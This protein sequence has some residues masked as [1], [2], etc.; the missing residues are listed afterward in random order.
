MHITRWKTAILALVCFAGL[1]AASDVQSQEPSTR[2]EALAEVISYGEMR[3]LIDQAEP[4]FH[5][6]NID[7]AKQII[8]RLASQEGEASVLYALKRLRYIDR[9]LA[10][11]ER[12]PRQRAFALFLFETLKNHPVGK[13]PPFVIITNAASRA[14][15]KPLDKDCLRETSLA[16]VNAAGGIPDAP[17]GREFQRALAWLARSLLFDEKF[18]EVARLTPLIEQSAIERQWYRNTLNDRMEPAFHAGDKETAR[19]ILLQ[20]AEQPGIYTDEPDISRIGSVFYDLDKAGELARGIAFVRFAFEEL[21]NHAISSSPQFVQITNPLAKYCGARGDKNCLR[22]TAALGIKAIGG[23]PAEKPDEFSHSQAL[24]YQAIALAMDGRLEEV[25]P[26]LRVKSYGNFERGEVMANDIATLVWDGTLS[27]TIKIDLQ[28]TALLELEREP[29]QETWSSVWRITSNMASELIGL[30]RLSEAEIVLRQNYDLVLQHFDWDSE[31]ASS[32]AEA[33]A[34]I[35]AMQGRWDEAKVYYERNWQV[36]QSFGDWSIDLSTE[37][38]GWVSVLIETGRLDEADRITDEVWR[39]TQAAEKLDDFTKIQ[40]AGSRGRVLLRQGRLAEAETAFRSAYE[41]AGDASLL[42]GAFLAGQLA[43]TIERQSRHAEAEP[44][45]RKA[46]EISSDNLQK[47][48]FGAGRIAA[49]ISLADNLS[50][51][52]KQ[53]DANE[54]Y[55]KALTLARALEEPS[56]QAF[57]SVSLAYAQHLFRLGNMDEAA[58]YANIALNSKALSLDLLGA[59]AG[60]TAYLTALNG[61]RSAAIL[62]LEIMSAK[63]ITDAENISRVLNAAQRAQASSASSALSQRAAETL[64]EKAGAGE[65]VFRW[66]LAQQNV[67][68]LDRQNSALTGNGDALGARRLALSSQREEA[69]ALLQKTEA[70]LE[71]RFPR[72]FDLARPA[73]ATL[74]AV[75]RSL[76]EDEALI[77]LVPSGDERTRAEFSGLVI[78]LT[79]SGHAIA[80]IALE[81]YDLAS[82]IDDLQQGLALPGSGYTHHPDFLAPKVIYSRDKAHMLYNALFSDP[83]IKKII[84]EK[85]QWTLAP[86]DGLLGVSYAALVTDAPHGGKKGDADPQTLRETKWLGMER[87]LAI[88]PSVSALIL[89]RNADLEAGRASQPFFG[90]GDPAFKGVADP[91]VELPED[92]RE[93]TAFSNVRA[94]NGF[95]NYYTGPVANLEALAGLDRLPGTAIEVQSLAAVLAAKP[96]SV[97]TQLDATQANLTA[98]NTSG[99]LA[100]SAIIIFATHGLIANELN[101]S[102]AEPALALTPPPGVLQ[103]D[104]TADNDGLLTASEAAAL[105]LTAD[106]LILSACNTSAGSRSSAQGLSGLARGFLYAGARSLLVSHFPVS[107]RA[108]PL[109]TV[110]AVETQRE[111]GVNK[112][113][114]MREA[115]RLMLQ[116]KRD[117]DQGQSLAHPKAWAALALISPGQ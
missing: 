69:F 51:Q 91:P 6:G 74:E 64:A 33:L 14:C 47:G 112:A 56:Q 31:G 55:T 67:S 21:K 80:P 59:G 5:S 87:A 48:T 90:F 104:L 39:K 18:D 65:F 35:L 57:G 44:L 53:D 8:L 66:R 113:E 96:D 71:D 12:N 36:A 49:W 101:G 50:I 79:R 98:Q 110:A 73:P 68:N 54:F 93:R 11:V 94:A 13:T 20:L 16:G 83:A 45:R 75:Q 10:E 70:E 95:A 76:G 102:I 78:A 30:G 105:R 42:G 85:S 109:L 3:E 88:T 72:F 15:S 89:A 81:P 43:E 77:L 58:E 100:D 19:H 23:V 61:Q 26:I 115:R 38:R 63:S 99:R 9:N 28:K 32:S 7:K 114:A 27:A 40:Y 2:P 107:D 116:N 1:V 37:L 52:G 86:Q 108:V 84:S 34:D 25:A 17:P 82:L 62:T 92:L 29:Q 4:I 60:E 117:D 24:L 103:K 46:I 41:L 106:W 111:T 97:I 22:E